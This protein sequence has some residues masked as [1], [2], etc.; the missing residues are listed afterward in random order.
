MTR[1][2]SDDQE[3]AEWLGERRAARHYKTIRK[4]ISGKGGGNQSGGRY[5]VRRA[6]RS[7]NV[8]E[9]L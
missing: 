4:A 2:E 6:L 9:K 5:T 3:C 7:Q 1:M 8:A